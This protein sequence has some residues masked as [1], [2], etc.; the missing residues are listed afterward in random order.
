MFLHIF[1]QGEEA[2]HGAELVRRGAARWQQ[3]LITR[4]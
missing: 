1:N 3:Y 4:N 2:E